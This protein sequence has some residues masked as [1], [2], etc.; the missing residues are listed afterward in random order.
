MKKRMLLVLFIVTIPLSVLFPQDTTRVELRSDLKNQIE[1]IIDDSYIRIPKK[2]FDTMIENRLSNLVNSKINA[3][4][5]ITV[6]LITLLSLFSIFQFNKS[7]VSNEKLIEAQVNI[8]AKESILDIQ[9]F[10]KDNI[11]SKLAEIEKRLTQNIDLLKKD[12]ESSLTQIHEQIEKAKTQVKKAEDYLTNLEIESLTNLIITEKKYQLPEDLNRAQ[13]I[14]NDI[15]ASENKF[16]IP[17]VVNLLSYIYYDQKQYNEVN[18]LISTYEKDFKLKSN[19]YINGALTALNDYHNYNSLNQRHKCIEYL[20]KSLELTQGYGEALGLKL[21]VYMMD[22]LRADDDAVKQASKSSA[23]K[24]IDGILHSENRAPSYETLSRLER[25][26]QNASY[27]KYVITLFT[28]FPEKMDALLKEANEAADLLKIKP[29]DIN[30][31]T[32]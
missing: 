14:L 4:I 25:D 32:I 27:N 31:F 26:A 11:E 7:R 12:N 13:N 16:Q 29:F 1:E 8:A 28:E 10:Y 30:E 23:L 5:G 15:E 17:T 18:D 24:V 21:E 20:D 19:T 22:F 3:L 9:S 6:G 2:D